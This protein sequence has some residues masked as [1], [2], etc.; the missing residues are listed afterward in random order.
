[1]TKVDLLKASKK[2]FED[3]VNNAVVWSCKRVFTSSGY[4]YLIKQSSKPISCAIHFARNFETSDEVGKF[5]N[6][7]VAINTNE[8]IPFE[9]AVIEYKD[10]IVALLSQRNY[11]E[12]MKMW[13]YNGVGSFSPISNFFFVTS[14]DEIIHNLGVNSMQIFCELKKDYPIVPSYFNAQSTKKYIMV[15]IEEASEGLNSVL[16]K[17]IEGRISARKRDNVKL[18]FVNF[19]RDEALAELHRIQEASLVES[20]KFGFVSA[21]KLENKYLYQ[22]AFN[23]KSN[24]YIATFSIFYFISSE[25]LWPGKVIE[26]VIYEQLQAI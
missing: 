6:I 3:K 15:D 2:E 7:E 19:T 24:T 16:S 14:E 1:M 10:F 18:T 20:P 13:H 23:W 4:A 8:E 22:L 11:N 5:E 25:A 12:T 21:P 9:D 26:E 17:D